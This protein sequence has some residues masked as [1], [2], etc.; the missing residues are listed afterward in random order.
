MAF[1]D[2]VETVKVPHMAE[3]L[4]EGT[5]KTWSKQVGDTV[6]MD[7]EVASIETDKVR[8]SLCLY[9]DNFPRIS[10]CCQSGHFSE[11]GSSH[12]TLLL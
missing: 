8:P 1:H 12:I 3:S 10:P 4:T 11:Q 2:I 5:L 9:P 7:E 6:E